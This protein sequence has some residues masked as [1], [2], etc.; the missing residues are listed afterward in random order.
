MGHQ[1]ATMNWS[2]VTKLLVN[3]FNILFVR[4][5]KA[6]MYWSIVTKLLVIL[7]STSRLLIIT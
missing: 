6:T 7:V 2:I 3:I 4:P 1:Y 5:Q